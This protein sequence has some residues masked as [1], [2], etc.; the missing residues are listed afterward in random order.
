MP[1]LYLCQIM[2]LN[3][4]A[5]RPSSHSSTCNYGQHN[6]DQSHAPIYTNYPTHVT[7]WSKSLSWEANRSS[8]TQKIACISRNP[9]GYYHIQKSL[10]ICPYPEPDQSTPCPSYHFWNIRFNLILSSH[11]CLGLPSGLFSSG[12]ANKNLYAPFLF[13][14][15]VTC[16]APLI[17]SLTSGEMFHNVLSFYWEES[18]A[19]HP[20]PKLEDNPLS[21]V[22]NCLFNTFA[23]TLHIWRLFLHPQPED[24]PCCSDGI[25]YHAPVC[26]LH[27]S[28]DIIQHIY[29]AKITIQLPSYSTQCFSRCQWQLTVEITHILW[30]STVHYRHHNNTK[31]GSSALYILPGPH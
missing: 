30:N 29:N 23:A 19:P 20:N 12:T 31:W 21:A 18:F 4:T 17:L 10:H 5:R 11:L 9:K 14:T 16:P 7:T 25:T 22:H 3:D 26:T 24:P 28:E 15:R 13:P 8:S 1:K 27:I 2:L 6:T